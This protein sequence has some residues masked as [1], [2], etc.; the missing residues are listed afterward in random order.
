MQVQSESLT[1]YLG[2][3]YLTTLG[4]AAEFS[5]TTWTNLASGVVLLVDL[6]GLTVASGSVVTSGAAGTT[7]TIRVELPRTLLDVIGRG[8]R[9]LEIWAWLAG[10]RY[11]L[12]DLVLDV[13]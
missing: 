10:N 12:V 9:L 2:T 4:N 7:Q 6:N 5:A 11:G 13:L 1:C 3:D 8:R